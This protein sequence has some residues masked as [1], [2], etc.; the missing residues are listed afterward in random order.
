MHDLNN[1]HEILNCLEKN[2]DYFLDY[3]DWRIEKHASIIAADELDI[4]EAFCLDIKG[5]KKTEDK[6]L[7]F[8][9]IGPSIIDKIYFQNMELLMHIQY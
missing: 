3:V 2:V 9:P 4:F 6:F 5:I 7:I 8:W 1:I